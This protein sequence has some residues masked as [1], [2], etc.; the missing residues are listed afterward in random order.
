MQRRAKLAQAADKA[1]QEAAAKAKAA[2]EAKAAAD[3]AMADAR[4]AGQSRRRSQSRRRKGHRR[5]RRQS[6]RSHRRAA[7]RGQD[8][9]EATNQAKPTNINLAAP[10]PT[11]TLQDHGRA[12]HDERHAAG[13]PSSKARRSRSR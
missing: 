6:E 12:D 1:A 11:V 9:H 2:A 7:N 5:R 10:S 8:R 13:A 3:K 4:S